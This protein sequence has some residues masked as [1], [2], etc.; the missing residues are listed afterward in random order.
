M[1]SDDKI[2]PALYEDELEFDIF[3]RILA[4][5]ETYYDSEGYDTAVAIPLFYKVLKY[6]I[7]K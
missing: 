5:N 4:G 2:E 7:C 1:W 6:G 3:D